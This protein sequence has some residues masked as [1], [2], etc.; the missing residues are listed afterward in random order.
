[1]QASLLN[2]EDYYREVLRQRNI[3][4]TVLQSVPGDIV[5]LLPADLEESVKTTIYKA[6]EQTV[7]DACEPM[8][9]LLEGDEDDKVLNV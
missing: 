6:V 9:A 3:V 4:V 5:S 2:A 1:M 7:A 8:D